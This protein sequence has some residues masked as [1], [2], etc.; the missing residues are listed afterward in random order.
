MMI[1]YGFKIFRLVVIVFTL[2][3]FIGCLFYVYSKEVNLKSTPETFI[4]K[5][6][7]E[8]KTDSEK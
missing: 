3:Y 1:V 4:T 6:E 5:F 7:L 8:T 2:S